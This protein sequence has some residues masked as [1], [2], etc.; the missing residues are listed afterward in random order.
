MIT[1]PNKATFA[2]TT[3]VPAGLQVISN[4][5][6]L[7]GPEPAGPGLV[8]WRWQESQPMTT[9]LAFVAIG[10]YIIVRQD[11]RFGLYLAAYDQ[12]LQ[13]QI[14]T[15][16]RS[17]VEQTRQ[18]IDFLSGIFG[19]YPFRQLGGIVPDAPP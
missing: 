10:H 14:A 18:I 2:I 1:P 19:P 5:A 17:S 9:Y 11:T 8:Q 6:L 13:P 4:G 12:N 3:I 16:A 15:A 7:G